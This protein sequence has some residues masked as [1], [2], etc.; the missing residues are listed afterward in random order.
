[1]ANDHR[2]LL[3]SSHFLD[4]MSKVGVQEHDQG[5]MML[6]STTPFSPSMSFLEM[7]FQCDTTE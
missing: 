3:L 6:L 7:L 2:D 4:R 5:D 1:M